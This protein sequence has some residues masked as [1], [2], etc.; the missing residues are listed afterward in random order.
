M[1]HAALV[2]V[3]DGPG[4]LADE[5][6]GAPGFQ[7]VSVREARQ[8]G[9]FD[10]PHAVVRLVEMFPH[11]INRHDVRVVQPGGGFGLE[12]ESLRGT[13]AEHPRASDHLQGHS[14][15][16]A[17]LP[18]LVHYAHTAAPDLAQQLVVAEVPHTLR[19][20][21]RN[22]LRTALRGVRYQVRGTHLQ[23]FLAR[24]LAQAGGAEAG[25]RGRREGGVTLRAAR[26]SGH[27]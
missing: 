10:Q 6:R 24:E 16:E 21:R 8:A 4:D 27:D 20:G 18:R 5:A 13:R 12:L 19:R 11:L 3:V 2:R 26:L 14:T 1:E 9:A 7:G 25:R 23:P 15:F 22:P 17:E